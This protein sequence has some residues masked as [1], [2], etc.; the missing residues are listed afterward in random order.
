MTPEALA[1]NGLDVVLCSSEPFPFHKKDKF[2]AELEDAL[3]D[4]PVEVV[5]GQPFSWYGPRLLDTPTYLRD[6]RERLP[7]PRAA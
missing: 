4:T 3:P 7:T 5:D 1:E 2:T 6:L